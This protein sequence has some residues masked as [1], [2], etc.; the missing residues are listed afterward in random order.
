[1]QAAQLEMEQ[2]QI[3]KEQLELAMAVSQPYLSLASTE[4]TVYRRRGESDWRRLLEKL[5]WGEH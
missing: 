2:A 3:E 5:S 1:M 4:A